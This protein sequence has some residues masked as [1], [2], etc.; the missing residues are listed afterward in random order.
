M[1][2]E[3]DIRV[4]ATK[5]VSLEHSMQDIRDDFKSGQVNMMNAVSDLAS[6]VNRLVECDIKRDE[7]D[8]HEAEKR[9]SYE[10]RLNRLEG[11]SLTYK[12]YIAADEP[13]RGL[14]K[15]AIGAFITAVVTSIG[16]LIL[17]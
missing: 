14:R 5:V 12:L 6:S 15:L 1:P 17:K 3:S 7:R 9:Q 10:S 8:K 2:E 11:D 4:L 13:I 16:V